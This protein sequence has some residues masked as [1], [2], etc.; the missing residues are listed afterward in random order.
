MERQIIVALPKL[1]ADEIER[2]LHELQAADP[3]IARAILN[4]ALDAAD[5][6]SAA[7]RYLAEYHRVAE[8]LKRTRGSCL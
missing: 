1:S 6:V 5:P 8:Q 4:A 7:R 2:L 3:Q